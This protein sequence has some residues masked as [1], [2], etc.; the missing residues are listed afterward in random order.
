MCFD[1]ADFKELFTVEKI[2]T[3]HG[4]ATVAERA[5]RTEAQQWEGHA[6]FFRGSCGVFGAGAK[7]RRA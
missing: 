5:T 2:S 1:L 6:N 3:P 4:V 7:T